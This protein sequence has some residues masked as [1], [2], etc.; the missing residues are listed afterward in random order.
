MRKSSRP[1]LSSVVRALIVDDTT[2]IHDDYR[3]I[4]EPRQSDSG[5]AD[6]EASLFGQSAARKNTRATFR[7]DSAYQSDEAIRAVERAVAEGDPY[8][9]AF[10]DARMPPGANGIE[11]LARMWAID[12]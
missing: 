8:A 1:A 3:K 11:T 6:L 12:P 4:L 2:L 10:V 7:L 9:I 5:M